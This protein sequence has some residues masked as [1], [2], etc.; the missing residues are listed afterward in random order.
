MTEKVLKEDHMRRLFLRMAVL[1]CM[2][3]SVALTGCVDEQPSLVIA[4]AIPYG[5]DCVPKT[6]GDVVLLQGTYDPFCGNSYKVAFEVWSYIISRADKDRPRAET[7]IV[8]FERAEIDL[9]TPDGQEM[10]FTTADGQE[11]PTSFS[12]PV[13]GTVLP[14]VANSPGKTIVIVNVI[15]SNIAMSI[16]E[17]EVV[18]KIKLFGKTNGDVDVETGPYRY[19]I[20]ICSGCF[21]QTIKKCAWSDDELNVFDNASGCQNGQG[22]DGSYCWCNT[23]SSS[24]CAAC[25][26][27]AQ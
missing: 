8:K 3:L 22:F 1:S 20:S 25:N 7:N 15:P 21:T 14:G 10:G 16:S 13:S 17:P 11:A 23:N 5:D 18:A 2:A 12:V 26:L 4:N 6:G 27:P 9:I 24:Q 19:P